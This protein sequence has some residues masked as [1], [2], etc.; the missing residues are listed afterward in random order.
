MST[1]AYPGLLAEGGID[2]GYLHANVRGLEAP[3]RRGGLPCENLSI[4]N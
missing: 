4:Q 2:A 1:D 3:W